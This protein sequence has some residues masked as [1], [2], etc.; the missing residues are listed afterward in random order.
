VNQQLCQK[1][2]TRHLTS[3]WL[4]LLTLGVKRN[5]VKRRDFWGAVVTQKMWEKSLT[6]LF[7]PGVVDFATAQGV[8]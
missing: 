3:N 7:Q 1:I 8:G 2:A 4:T 6:R 5:D